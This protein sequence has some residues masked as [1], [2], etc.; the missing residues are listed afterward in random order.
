MRVALQFL[1][2]MELAINAAGAMASCSPIPGAD[3]IW[4]KPSVHWVFIG[5]LHGST[6][7]PAAFRDLVSDAIAQGQHVT[8]ALERPTSEQAALNNLPTA[9]APSTPQ[10]LQLRLPGCNEGMHERA[11][12]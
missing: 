5:E 6:E 11:G 9:K 12:E 1:L 10:E 3:Q 7:T 8:V 2:A 4:T